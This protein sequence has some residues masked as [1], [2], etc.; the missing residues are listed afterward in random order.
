MEL[1]M[2]L[3]ILLSALCLFFSGCGSPK[4]TP[5]SKTVLRLNIVDDPSSLQP[6]RVR[7][8]QSI[9]T[10]RLLYE[11]LMRVGFDGKPHPALCESYEISDEGKTY[12]FHLRDSVWS[13]GK[14][15][16]AEDFIQAWKEALDP[17]FP[18]DYAFHFFVIK[19]A[20]EIKKGEKGKETL[21]VAAL[22]AKTLRVELVTPIPY[23]LEILAFPTFFPQAG[24]SEE[25]LVTNGPFVISQYDFKSKLTLEK[26]PLYWNKDAVKL[27]AIDLYMV[28]AGTEIQLFEQGQID[29]VGSPI[30]TVPLEAVPTFTKKGLLHKEPYLSTYYVQFN[31]TKGILSNVKIRKALAL[32]IEREK[33][34]EKALNG[35]QSRTFSFVPRALLEEKERKLFEDKVKAQYLLED[36]LKELG[37]AKEDV[38]LTYIYGTTNSRLVAEVLQEEWKNSL[39]IDVQLQAIEQKYYFS[40]LAEKEFDIA[41][42]S[43]MADVPDAT[44]FLDNF[45]T[46]ETRTNATGWDNATYASFVQEAKQQ[47]EAKRRSDLLEAAQAILLEEAPIVP[48]YHFNM[49]YLKNERLKDIVLTDSG[50]WDVSFASFDETR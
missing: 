40:K 3:V 30:S 18:C 48:I 2:R 23:F 38:H 17:A 46:K 39:G 50:V 29:W 27:S 44:N 25:A 22:D 15:L 31:T 26:N 24:G 42:G 5:Q 10:S 11:G 9:F 6:Q 33:I 13:N 35:T 47:N 1:T 20:Q 37:M 12:T 32:S 28:A 49:L 36:G 41:A 7:N 8:L 19:N 14:K 45:L 21:G 16:E 43:W 4:D 34:T